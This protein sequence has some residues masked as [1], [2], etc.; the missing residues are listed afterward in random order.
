MLTLVWVL[1]GGIVG[2]ALLV[3]AGFLAA[4]YFYL[5]R[6]PDEIHFATGSDGCRIAVY[7][8]RPV[9]PLGEVPVLMVPGLGANHCAF[10]LTDQCSLA[11]YLAG[12]GYDAWVVELRG[13]GMSTR[14]QL[15]SGVRYDWCFDE[16][17]ERDLPAA[18]TTVTRVT[19]APALHLLGFSI[20]ALAAYAW[21]SD[22][23]RQTEV[24]SLTSLG[25]PATFKRSG[26]HLSGPVLRNL[27]WLRHRFLMRVL[28]PVSGYW[29]PSPVQ[30]IHNPENMDGPTQ[31]R[32][33]VNLIA[34]FSRNELL[35]YSDWLSHDVFR[36]IDQRRDYR[37]EL[38]RITVPALF[39]AGARDLLAPPDAVKHAC[40]AISSSDKRFVILSRA[41]KFSVNYGHFDM[42]LGPRA[43]DEVYPVVR[44][45][46]AAHGARANDHEPA[47]ET[48]PEPPAAQAN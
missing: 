40:D 31:R 16:Y 47:P 1:L 23:H 39:M 20:G 8:Y 44:E 19:G 3:Y 11:R 15:F 38:P 45:W 33:M 29:H 14:P 18:A 13:R 37:A 41:Q 22:P 12:A 48:T 10:D 21:L 9:Q 17:A 2:L 42:L 46:L 35:Q 32:A 26:T 28:A 25:G 6:F 7:R 24:L 36:S 4:R 34:N 30:L 5:P 43:R 27:R